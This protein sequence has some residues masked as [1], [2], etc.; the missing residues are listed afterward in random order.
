[1][2]TAADFEK[3]VA[4]LNDKSKRLSPD[5]RA[6]VEEAV[7]EYR[8]RFLNQGAYADQGGT[9]ADVKGVLPNRQV[10]P[11]GAGPAPFDPEKA[12]VDALVSRLN[13]MQPPLPQVLATQP[14]TTHPKGDEEAKDDWIR[15]DVDA[16]N[17]VVVYDTPVKKVREDLLDNPQLY[18]A[19]KL[20]VP[21][22]PEEVMRIQSGDSTHQAYNDWKWRQTADELVKAGK[23]PYRYS[24]APFM[25]G[26][27]NAGILDTIKTK[28]SA[29]TAPF[30]EG[31]T[32]FVMGIDKTGDFGA[33]RAALER[34]N[35]EMGTAR[36]GQET[37]GGIPDAPARERNAMLEEEHP[38]LYAAGEGIGALAPW[39]LTNKL[40]GLTL[41]GA[42]KVASRAT[43]AITAP[44]ARVGAA[45]AGGAAGGALG[46]LG[47]EGVQALSTGT[48]E[49]GLPRRVGRAAAGG[50]AFSAG[51]K[52]A[53]EAV[54]GFGN[55]VREGEYFEGMPGRIERHGVEP[56]FGRGYVDPPEVTAAKLKAKSQGRDDKAIDML[57][58]EL[59]EP[60]A[61][62][63]I[64]HSDDTNDV[65]R[66][67]NAEV[68]VSPEGKELL[69]TKATLEES[70]TQLKQ[71]TAS[72][73]K[74]QAPTAVG[75]PNAP[76]AIKGVFNAHIE[77]V[78][79]K[80]Q[81]GWIP[82][83]A[84]EAEA[85]LNPVMQKRA[86]QSAR[87]GK[88][89]MRGDPRA[90][91]AAAAPASAA[92]PKP[93]GV[94]DFAGAKPPPRAARVAGKPGAFVR[95]LEKRGVDTVY[96]APRLLDAEHQE[97]AIRRL[98]TKARKNSKDPD[99]DKIYRAAMEDRK[100]RV[101]QGQK[102]GFS[103]LQKKH[104]QDIGA[105]KKTLELVAP[106]GT[107]AYNQIIKLAKQRTGQSR[108]QQA[109]RDTAARAGG[110]APAKLNASQVMDPMDKLKRRSS[111]GRDSRGQ[112]RSVLGLPLPQLGDLALM[113]GLYP[114][115]RKLEKVPLG[116]YAAR[117]ARAKRI[118]D[119]RAEAEKKEREKLAPKA[120][121]YAERAG[122]VEPKK[123]ESQ[124]KKS[125]RRRLR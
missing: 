102:G 22:Q 95:K 90:P 63:A 91:K 53:E 46:Q 70:Y 62:A 101:W 80:P 109:L 61:R 64:K 35:P 41:G 83:P 5:V 4:L 121:G 39:S 84:N 94:I 8:T 33:G 56:Q 34:A 114:L 75:V 118:P 86:L 116:K 27:K 2:L 104:S 58:E 36:L 98:R 87:T 44:L 78:S 9:M 117:L 59:D 82:V 14:A 1:M 113:R 28:V 40:F 125:H 71:R 54:Q 11:A 57:A 16:D 85:F 66:R 96:V 81:P 24:R 49:D 108:G 32:A 47:E 120:A 65:V 111:F 110:D 115:T 26:G 17:L 6:A 73:N 51:G 89:A 119:D 67:E 124:A 48:T 77:G 23:T 105:A 7:S 15:G 69:P 112:K 20:D 72:N 31:A 45:A 122:A 13:P 3:K 43:G 42:A 19:L 21:S 68:Y 52:V 55:W 12:K 79:T 50:A 92:A 93:A 74:K 60:M 88:P 18:R 30:G 97:S 76:N 99:Q 123:N 10:T 106:G 107:S 38:M 25:A 29:A 103:R 100:Q 37:R